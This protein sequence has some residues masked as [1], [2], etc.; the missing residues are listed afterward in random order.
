MILSRLM[1]LNTLITL[2]ACVACGFEAGGVDESSTGAS[3]GD[4][5]IGEPILPTGDSGMSTGTSLPG[6]E[7]GASTSDG[8]GSTESATTGGPVCGDGVIDPGEG[9][10][11]G[12][13]NQAYNAC[14]D[15]CQPNVCGDGKVQTG[16]E[17]CDEGMDNVDFGACRSDCQL[18]VCGDGF[19]YVGVEECDAGVTNGP[20]YGQCDEACTINRCGDGVLDVGFE[21]C[22]LGAENGSGRP[23]EDGMSGCDEDCGYTGR[24][25]FLS[26]QKF[27]GNMG[28]RAGADLAC[29]NMAKAV[30]FKYPE[31]FVSLLAD[32]LGSPNTYIPPD[33]EGRPFILPSGL[34]LADDYE[35]LIAGGPGLG[36]TATET[37]EILTKQL[38][39][40]NLNPLG[41]AYLTD[42]M[43]TCTSW[44]SADENQ[45]A[46]VGLNG[47][48][49]NDPGFTT[50]QENR[51]WLSYASKYCEDEFRIYCIEAEVE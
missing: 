37:G 38:V 28:T 1:K 24:R 17:A 26:S 10:D 6:T 27:S 7:T 39:W 45:L 49:A 40:T 13:E 47:V 22:D 16:T 4:D 19:W 41:G 48:P 11:D 36:I 30:L 25:V 51:Q 21:V 9:C 23:G 44:S 5:P 15:E 43:N 2:S 33:P 8:G 42:A 3:T 35:D 20:E 50:W 32:G 46:R 29:V 34:I 18:N 12:P 31:R 14:T